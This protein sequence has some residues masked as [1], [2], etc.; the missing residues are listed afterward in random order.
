MDPYDVFLGTTASEL[1][2]INADSSVVRLVP[3]V[4][5]GFPA[6]AY[7]GVLTGVEHFE[8]EPGGTVHVS[9]RDVPISVRFPPDYLRSADPSLQFRVVRVHVPLFHPNHRSG[10]LCLGPAFHPGSR[11]RSL[12][13][14]V[15]GIVSGR[16]A[17]T[18]HGFDKDA[19]DYFLAHPEEVRA[20]RAQPLWRQAIATRVRVEEVA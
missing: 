18:D 6:A 11:L 20:L 7:D 3:A 1:P 2:Q 14:Q 9:A 19:C 5:A 10:S 13:E 15:F 4:G 8:L 16:I 12:V 17:A